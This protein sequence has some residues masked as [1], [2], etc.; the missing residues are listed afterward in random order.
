MIKELLNNKKALVLITGG[1]IGFAAGLVIR[2]KAKLKC[3]EIIKEFVSNQELIEHV[4]ETSDEYSEEDR[5]QD[6]KINKTQTTIKIVKAYAPTYITLV[7]SGILV[8]N[9][10]ISLKKSYNINTSITY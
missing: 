4:A 5:Q 10:T 6:I 8:I 7:T 9:G 1:A 2:N 3:A